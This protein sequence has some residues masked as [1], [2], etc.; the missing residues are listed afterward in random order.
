MFAKQKSPLLR[1]KTTSLL[2]PREAGELPT[3]ASR[4]E[5]KATITGERRNNLNASCGWGRGNFGEVTRTRGSNGTF[6]AD[7]GTDAFLYVTKNYVL[8][9]RGLCFC[10]GT[11]WDMTSYGENAVPG[12]RKHSMMSCTNEVMHY[13]LRSR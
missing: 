10:T 11:E 6:R 13:D 9:F 12:V 1:F 4:T 7:S 5:A 8:V 3:P 2:R